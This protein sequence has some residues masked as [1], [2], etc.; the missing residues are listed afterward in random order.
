MAMSFLCE[1]IYGERAN[2]VHFLYQELG[3]MK[4]DI[5][6][7][8]FTTTSYQ[9]SSLISSTLESSFN[10][11]LAFVVFQFT[12]LIIFS[13]LILTPIFANQHNLTTC[14]SSVILKE[15]SNHFIEG[16]AIMSY[17]LELIT[18]IEQFHLDQRDPYWET[19]KLLAERGIIS[20]QIAKG[21]L[22]EIES[23]IQRQKDFPNYLHGPPTAAQFYANGPP[24]IRLG[25]LVE[26]PDIIFGIRFDMPLHIIIAGVTGFGKTTAAR[27][28]QQGVWEYN[29][30]NPD[31][32]K[33]IIAFDRKS[34]DYADLPNSFGWL[35]YSIPHTLR[36]SLEAPSGV[37]PNEWI[38]IISTLFCS[39]TGLKA[40]WVTVANAL[41]WL[42]AALN[43]NPTNHLIWPDLNMLLDVLNT[44]PD[45]LFSSKVEYSRAARQPLEGIKHSSGNVF[46]AFR[47]FQVERD[48][49]NKGKSAVIS[50]PN[51]F[52]SWTRQFFTDVIL[53]QLLYSRTY[54]S[55]RVDFTE[56][57]VII[58]EADSDISTE[59]EEMFADRMC[60]V[61]SCFKTGR[62]FGIS[63][64][65][66]ISSLRSASR[67]VLSNATN[68]FIF[69][70][71]DAESII[72]ASRTLMLPP[73]GELSLNSLQPGEC[74]VK[75]IGPWPHAMI[76]KIDY[77]PPC[78]TKPDRYDTHPYEPAKS[79][80]ELPEVKHLLQKAIAEHRR[81]SLRQARQS[82][83]ARPLGKL[84]RTFLD[85]ASL[86][87]HQ[88]EPVHIIFG[89]IGKI[90][91]ATQS[92]VM[93]ELE[94]KK[95]AEF[96]RFRAGKSFFRLLNITDSGWSFLQKEPASKPGKGSTVHS[97]ICH[98]VQ[99]V[100]IKRGYEKSVFEWLVSG[101][102]HSCDVGFKIHG[103]WHGIEVVVD[104]YSNI[105]DHVK[106]CFIKSKV[107]ETL[108]IVTTTK[109]QW[110]KIRTLLMS[111]QE[112]LFFINRIKFE[113]A[114]TYMKELWP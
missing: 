5:I 7:N 15:R 114:E 68:H 18:K 9:R 113:V 73:G 75:Q 35:H 28:L 6:F 62:E 29:Q 11:P 2:Q 54:R 87:K 36:L 78:R 71:N 43:P 55:H 12:A 89:H 64:C 58:D 24:D 60:P 34:N 26:S 69:R 1:K 13:Y 45:T 10:S 17:R 101:T 97:H 46:R 30:L 111:D 42:L 93:N 104:C 88:Y 86:P 53:A 20:E 39:R 67:F 31:N 8:N 94:K 96:C 25:S 63:V 14:H 105:V 33:S 27:A 98:W 44:S 50:M 66:L 112:T 110:E 85:Y 57:L 40:S 95:L 81:T 77:M 90:P 70:L 79:L 82:K 65:V 99:D 41:R 84:S 19:M 107:V 32:V 100:G 22:Y 52:P 4:K 49:V 76:G 92:A 108:T 21:L 102:N 103:K 106:E 51:M 74:L 59:A 23:P 91:P 16:F 109:S 38:N 3:K 47:G 61:S 72:E 37:P 48:V 83:D 56:V 80:Q